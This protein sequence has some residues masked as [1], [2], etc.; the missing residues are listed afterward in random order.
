MSW[1]S[2][3]RVRRWGEL[4]RYIDKCAIV[5]FLAHKHVVNAGRVN[6]EGHEGKIT[7]RYFGSD[8]CCVGPFVTW[9][10]VS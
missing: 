10:Y 1:L 3:R 5:P 8:A 2:R 9:V 7:Q 6:R 4:G